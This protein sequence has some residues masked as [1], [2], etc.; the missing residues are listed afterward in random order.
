MMGAKF[1]LMLMYYVL[2][3][4]GVFLSVGGQVRKIALHTESQK[5][6]HGDIQGKGG[7]KLAK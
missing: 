6:L 4:E 3:I 1:I 2:L 7:G 5:G